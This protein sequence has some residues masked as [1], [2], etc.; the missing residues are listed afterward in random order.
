MTVFIGA[1]DIAA[2][3]KYATVQDWLNALFAYADRWRATGAKVIVATIL[4]Q[5]IPGKDD[6]NAEV[7][8]RRAV[9]NPAIRAAIGTHVDA[10]AD[11]AADP[12]MGPEAAASDKS[13][14]Q[15]GLHPTDGCGFGCGGQGKLAVV[16]AA[17]LDRLMK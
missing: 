8:R 13:L 6:Y 4:P 16:Y 2:T 10:V 15:D 17:A 7:N 5:Q 3:W 12:V 1:N 9:A 14:Y 11:Y